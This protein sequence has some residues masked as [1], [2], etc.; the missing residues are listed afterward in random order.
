MLIFYIVLEVEL[1]CKK[2]D[3]T[4]LLTTTS[5][6]AFSTVVDRFGRLERF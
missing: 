3:V 5:R 1:L 4:L 2:I 6:L